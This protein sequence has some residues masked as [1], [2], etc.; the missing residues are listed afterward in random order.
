M[1]FYIP[2]NM[3]KDF[4]DSMLALGTDCILNFS[5]TNKVRVRMNKVNYRT[6]NGIVTSD[7]VMFAELSSNL[8]MGDYIQYNDEILL[9]NQ[10]KTNQFPKCYEIFSTACNTKFN[11]TRYSLEEYNSSG[12]IIKTAGNYP[13]VSNLYCVTSVG[14]FE[15]N[16]T[17]GSPGIIPSDIVSC[18]CQYNTSTKTITEGDNFLWMNDKYK[19]ISLDLTQVDLDGLD[20]ILTFHAK[21]VI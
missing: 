9:I 20:G 4:S 5:L 3:Q 8:K 14:S 17:N 1:R 15:F 7:E 16:I 6:K 11:I 19:V 21:K 12:D 2:S 18:Q 13:V 10:V